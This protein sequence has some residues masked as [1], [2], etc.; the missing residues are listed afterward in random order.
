VSA[1]LLATFAFAAV[2]A[3]I[4]TR[5]VRDFA[6]RKGLVASPD[7]KRHL[8]CEPIPRLGG[9]AIFAAFLLAL[10]FAWLAALWRSPQLAA[11]LASAKL[12]TI[13]GPALLIFALGVYDDLRSASPWFK[14][15]VQ[16]M[17]GGLLFW[18]G[19]R[20]LNLPVLF[21]DHQFSWIA[22]LPLTILWV[23][24][25]TNAFNLID[26]LDGLAAGSGLF[27]T[28]VVFVVA[29]VNHH[30]P[31]ALVTIALAGAILGF[32]KFNFNPATI[33]LG[34]SGSLLIGFLLSALALEGANK[35]PTVVA[36]A[37]PVVS[38]GLPILETTLSVMRRLISGRPVFTADREHIHHKLLDLGLSHRQVVI[39]LYAVSALFALLSLFLLWPTG[40]TL[41]LVLAVVGAGVWLGVQHLGY[42]EFGELRRVAQRTV[43]QRHIFINNLA[44]R[45]AIEE[46]KVARDY[47]QV[48]R[49]L[50]A[51]FEGNDFDS[52]ELSVESHADD[53]ELPDVPPSF[54]AESLPSVYRWSR[55]GA[56]RVATLERG[57]SL[58]LDLVTSSGHQRGMLR[59]SRTYMPRALQFDINLLTEHFPAALADALDRALRAKSDA[60]VPASYQ[61]Y[62]G[63]R[64]N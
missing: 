48:C 55:I 39:V 3:F 36:V 52:F 10:A 34:D 9:M 44:I 60:V 45:R 20:I 14:F 41:G 30:N 2:E 51:A 62:A 53:F 26:G 24:G 63:L 18:G 1:V 27:S 40:S 5:Y 38:F 64:P 42:L 12:V 15:G 46:L 13:L 37:I 17:A 29:L 56:Q 35:A 22:G 47:D 54:L 32:L 49:I 4:L 43:E 58:H 50:L 28:V 16:A 57:W 8:H 59:V 7:G 6:K 11:G 33:F 25:I 61:R 19:L 21:G 23:I 31:I